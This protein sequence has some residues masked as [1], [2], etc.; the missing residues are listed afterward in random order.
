MANGKKM[1]SWEQQQEE[2]K[3][4]AGEKFSALSKQ[5]QGQ[6]GPSTNSRGIKALQALQGFAMET[7]LLC[8]HPGKSQEVPNT[9]HQ[10]KA[11]T[12]W[13]SWGSSLSTGE[14]GGAFVG[15]GGI[16]KVIM[17][18]RTCWNRQREQKTPGAHYQLG[19]KDT[20]GGEQHP[21]GQP[22]S[23]PTLFLRRC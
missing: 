10:A 21:R 2:S 8:Q 7:G 1:G 13:V 15:S 20:G 19:D 22:C 16:L 9:L 3:I 5:V 18:L 14:N 12:H 11:V 4:G 23:S 6:D 17:E